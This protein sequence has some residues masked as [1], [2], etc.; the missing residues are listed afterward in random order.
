MLIF[1]KTH[2]FLI[3]EIVAIDTGFFILKCLF[4]KIKI[5]SWQIANNPYSFSDNISGMKAKANDMHILFILFLLY[6]LLIARQ[7]CA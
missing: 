1:S 3:M 4:L 6:Q 5:V 2:E 7:W